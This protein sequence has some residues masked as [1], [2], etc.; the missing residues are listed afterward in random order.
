MNTFS[1]LW[2]VRT[3][4]EAQEKIREPIA[5][6]EIG[7]PWNTERFILRQRHWIVSTGRETLW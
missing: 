7:E 2:N 6:L 1:R 5:D 4:Q 3:P